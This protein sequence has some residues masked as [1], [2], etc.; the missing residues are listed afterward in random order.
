M[1]PRPPWIVTST[2][3][4]S[5]APTVMTVWS[6]N[7]H[8]AITLA[9]G[10][11]CPTLTLNWSFRMTPISS[12]TIP[13]RP[14][15]DSMTIPSN[16]CEDPHNWIYTGTNLSRNRKNRLDTFA[17]TLCP[18]FIVGW[19]PLTVGDNVFESGPVVYPTDISFQEFTNNES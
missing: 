15:E 4:V 8:D 16:E 5:Y 11:S 7:A 13:S 6:V 19:R 2:W 1:K 18:K 3:T 14:R 12:E 9:A 17:C 10:C